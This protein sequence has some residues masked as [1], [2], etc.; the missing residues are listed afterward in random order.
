MNFLK[1]KLNSRRLYY[2]VIVCVLALS[3]SLGGFFS[4]FYQSRREL[5]PILAYHSISDHTIGFK[6]LTISVSDFDNQM[7]YL[8]DNGYTALTFDE[9]YSKYKKPIYITFDDGYSDNYQHAYQILK[10]YHMVA[11]VFLITKYLDKPGYLSSSQIRQMA[12]CISFQS[13]TVDHYRMRRLNDRAIEYECAESKRVISALTGKPVYVL[14]Y[15]NGAFNSEA[16]AIVSKFYSC[17]VTTLDGFESHIKGNYKIRR[18]SISPD[19][20]MDKFIILLQSNG[21]I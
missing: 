13:H 14:A 7:K 20:N 3:I 6:D 21:K 2:V 11:T 18:V 19:V 5:V 4:L 15:P 1:T 10:K 12:D 17:A 8:Y 9:D 16:I